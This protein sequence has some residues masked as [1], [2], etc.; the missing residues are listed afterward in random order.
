MHFQADL[1]NIA[2]CNFSVRSVASK[3]PSHFPRRVIVSQLTSKKCK[4]NPD[5]FHTGNVICIYPFCP[6]FA[7]ELRVFSASGM[8]IEGRFLG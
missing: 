8:K 2:E 5:S 1:I 3:L 7:A 6:H 4:D